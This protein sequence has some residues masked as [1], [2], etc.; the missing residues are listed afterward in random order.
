MT[1]TVHLLASALRERP[2]LPCEP[3][4]G[5][6]AVTGSLGPCLPRH[7]V[8]LESNCDQARFLAPESD[9][10]HV[11]VFY[12]WNAG[13]LKDG[14]KRQTC[15][16]RQSCWWCDGRE[17]REIRKPDIREIVL[18]GS[19]SVPWAMWVTTSYKKHGSLRAP[20]NYQTRG[21]IGF[22]E[23]VVNASD[24]VRVNEWWSRLTEAQSF[25]IGRTILETLDCPVHVMA[26]VGLSRW[27]TFERWARLVYQ[28]PLYA[29]LTYLLPSREEL[30]GEA[31]DA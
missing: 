16:E 14:R 23:L 21:V 25:G 15:P 4:E 2:P 30:A 28:T 11:D 27:Q 8:I 29:L 6:C 26:K 1:R 12:A 7:L 9:H 17:F 19:P 31:A 20:V 18:N 24:P 13:Y 22:E 5:I 10:V 3:Q